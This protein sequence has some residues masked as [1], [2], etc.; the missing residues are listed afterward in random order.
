MKFFDAKTQNDTTNKNN[1]NESTE[2]R[3]MEH[4]ASGFKPEHLL[5]LQEKITKEILST[6]LGKN[7]ME[8][9]QV[10]QPHSI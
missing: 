2:N 6:K 3:H 1:S 8:E 10:S 4:A 5:D 7:E 9:L